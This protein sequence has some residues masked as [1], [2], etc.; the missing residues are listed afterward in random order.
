MPTALQVGEQPGLDFGRHV[1]IRLD[2]P[3]GEVVAETSG[4]GDFGG[5]AGDQPG[6]V[7]VSQPV[8]GQSGTHGADAH[9]GFAGS[10]D[11]GAQDAAVEGRA[12]EPGAAR[13]G[14]D[15]LVGAG[16]EM[17]AQEP[18]QEG[19]ERDGPGRRRCLGWAEPAPAAAFVQGSLVRVDGEV[20]GVEV[21]VNRPGFDGGSSCE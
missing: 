11:G 4:L 15:E 14:E 18:D 8:E 12:P 20:S 16:V 6:F 2:D 9:V 19:R 5:A 13:V 1:R 3:V 21:E 7:A 10:V 17:L